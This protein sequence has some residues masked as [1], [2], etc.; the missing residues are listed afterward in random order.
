MTYLLSLGTT[1]FELRKFFSDCRAQLI[2]G[3][4]RV[5]NLPAGPQARIRSIAHELPSSTDE[6]VRA[7]F[8]KN[9][10]MVDPEEPD[11]LVGIFRRYEEHSESPSEEEARRYARSSLVHLFSKDP[12]A[13]LVEFLRSAIGGE[14]SPEVGVQTVAASSAAPSSPLPPTLARV[15]VDLVEGTDVDKNLEDLPVGWSNF[16]IGVQAAALGQLKEA[17]QAE[18]ALQA[19][20]HLKEVL[21]DY[22]RRNAAK[23]AFP[24]PATSGLTFSPAENFEGEFDYSHDEVLAYCT[25]SDR[26]T[27]VFLHPIAAIRDSQC[28]LLTDDARRRCFPESGDLISFFGT[29]HPRQPERGEVGVWRVAEHETQKAVRFHISSEK[30]QVYEVRSIPFA[31]T[32]YDSVREYL[33]ESLGRS[34]AGEVHPTLYELT[35][36][37][38]IGTRAGAIDPRRAEIFE[39]G[40]LAWG[41]LSALRLEGRIFVVGPLPKER[42]V[43]EC[44]SLGSSLR[45]LLKA[46]TGKI[47]GGITRSQARELGQYLDSIDH[48]IDALR[49]Q[50]MK[51]EMDRV[52]ANSEALDDLTAALLDAEALKGR[53]DTAVATE[54]ASQVAQKA[55]IKAE[56]QRLQKE[57]DEWEARVRKQQDEHK[58]LRDETSRLVKAAFQKARDDSIGTLADVA[59]FQALSGLNSPVQPQAAGELNSVAL[60]RPGIREVPGGSEGDLAAVL[61]AIGVAKQRATAIETLFKIAASEGLVFCMKGVAARLA[62]ERWVTS[63]GGGFLLDAVVGMIDP[64]IVAETLGRKPA[65]SSIGILDANL[66]ALDMYA[67]PLHDLI[68]T[69]V[70]SGKENV[71]V[72]KIVLSLTDSVGSLP[73]PKSFEHVSLVV[74]LDART[75]LHPAEDLEELM[76]R[77]TDVEEGLLRTAYWRPAA[78]RLHAALGKLDIELRC[79]AL[80]LLVESS[81]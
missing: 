71:G 62:V 75:P 78:D 42:G 18:E 74:N 73:F 54:A 24:G 53:I 61:T 76:A 27:A 8:S 3:G 63:L 58:R 1:E 15:M 7:W 56:I 25:K 31:S 52:I 67:R 68:I 16:I 22:L 6:V 41:S 17:Q 40:L 51:S 35:D 23:R 79:M 77:V 9:V 29:G 69:R 10:T 38:I 5:Q 70:S 43:Y 33:R 60:P 55:E 14:A 80:S 19:N 39:S 45:K 64:E 26:A 46:S 34:A 13:A 32:D 49:I 20:S 66:S 44:G 12:P 28:L 21:G 4:A 47:A 57:R 50:R 59:I 11:A 36:G 2:Q 65:P 81:S 37:L 30:R 48:G 72:P